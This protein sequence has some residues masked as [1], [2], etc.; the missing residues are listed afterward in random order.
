VENSKCSLAEKYI[1]KC[2][3]SQAFVKSSKN[4][5]SFI[6]FGGYQQAGEVYFNDLWEFN[7][8]SLVFQEIVPRT[9]DLPNGRRLFG[10][11]GPFFQNL[12][13]IFGG[14]RANQIYDDL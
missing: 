1:P 14:M 8:K 10:M 5:D 3:S 7:S 6:L 2:R 13:F 12:Y 9:N 11:A 4:S